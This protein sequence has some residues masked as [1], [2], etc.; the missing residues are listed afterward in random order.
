MRYALAI[1]IVGLSFLAGCAFGDGE[2][3][4]RPVR[5]GP[6]LIA[7]SSN[8]D[9]DFDL[10]VMRPDGSG[11]RQLTRNEA[12]RSSEARD[13]SPSFSPDGNRIAFVS[14]RDHPGGAL[15]SYELY[16]V[17]ADGSGERRLTNDLLAQSQPSWT[18]DG[19][20]LFG[21]CGHELRTCRIET[22]RPDGSDRRRV[23]AVPASIVLFG[24]GRSPDGSKVAFARPERGDIWAFENMDVYVADADWSDERRLTNDPGNDGG[25]L[26]S[27]DGAKL[28]FASDRD[29]NGRCLFHDCVGH[30][31][32]LYVMTADGS[33]QRRLTRTRATEG[34]WAWS[35]DGS[36]IVFARI[37]DEEDDYEL[38][39]M[40][41]DG[42][43][44]RRLTD[45][46]AWDWMP[47]WVGAGGGPL[48]C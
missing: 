19:R 10:Y 48:E 44:E 42:S 36:R 23:E 26:W 6:E 43:C 13:E 46:D 39:L 16:V 18:S 47:S 20:I 22:M 11:L 1:A 45:H 7:F 14:N 8:R 3:E 40:N 17:D 31:P 33:D 2:R 28:L 34:G 37:A 24:I 4:S 12:S 38:F 41:A 30:A 32:E 15:G 27:P 5:S 9:G 25:A 35:P 21:V 29:R